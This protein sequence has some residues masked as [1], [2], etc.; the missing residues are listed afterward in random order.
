MTIK[1]IIINTQTQQTT[2]IIIECL[3]E[4]FGLELEP[5]PEIGSVIEFVTISTES[6]FELVS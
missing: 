4:E 6:L 3:F 5:G 2:M 1:T